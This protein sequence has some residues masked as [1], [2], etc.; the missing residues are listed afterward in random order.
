MVSST[1]STPTETEAP[2]DVAESSAPDIVE[3]D[4]AEAPAVAEQAAEVPAAEAPVAA[5]PTVA[6][7]VAEVPAA[8]PKAAAPSNSRFSEAERTLRKERVAKA[9][10]ALARSV[11]VKGDHVAPARASLK[12]Y[13]QRLNEP[14]QPDDARFELLINGPFTAPPKKKTNDRKF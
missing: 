11:G 5:E 7:P 4:S 3:T 1:E 10:D 6:E 14:N 2:T 8:A 9:K 12:M 13:L